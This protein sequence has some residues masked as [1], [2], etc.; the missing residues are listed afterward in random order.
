MI[1]VLL[2][3]FSDFVH[4]LVNLDIFVGLLGAGLFVWVVGAVYKILY[5]GR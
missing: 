3:S 1:Y 2:S 4:T 5:G